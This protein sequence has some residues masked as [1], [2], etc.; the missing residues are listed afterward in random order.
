MTIVWT[1]P[2]PEAALDEAA[3][4]EDA[5]AAPANVAE[6]IRAAAE[7]LEAIDA[8]RG[9]LAPLAL[10]ERARLL[11]AARRVSNPD[12]RARRRLVKA[13]ARQRR[14]AEVAAEEAVLESTG[15]R[16]LRRKPVFTSPN[17]YP[18]AA[19][20]DRETPPAAPAGHT[21]ETR[22]CYVCKEHYR[23]VHHFYDQLCP[24]CAELNF[25]KRTELAD[26]R[27]RV[28]LLTGG[29]VKIG[30]QAG[31]KLLR[32][33]AQLL[34]TTRFPRDSA[35]RFAAEPDFADWADRLQIFGL[36]LR[37]TPSVEAFCA[38]LLHTRSRLDF[39][40]N[41]ACQTVRRP[42]GFYQHMMAAEGAALHDLP[43]HVRR[44][45]GA[46]EGLRAYSLL[47]EAPAQSR[48]ADGK[49]ALP[50]LAERLSELT[51]ITHAAALSQVALLPEDHAGEHDLFPQGVLDQDLQQVD[52]RG[53]NSWRLLL[54]EVSSVELLEVQLVNAVA[55]FVLNAR[56]KSLMI[57][58]PE[59]DKHIVNVSAM[60]GQ[61]YRNQ[62]TT[63]HPHTNMAKAALNMMTRTSAADYVADG[64]HMNS[65][66]TGWVTDED[67]A[68][69]AA[70]K[71]VE[72]RFHPPLDIVDG[73]AR[74]VDPIL[75][76]IN[77]GEHV[78]GKFL[79][80]YRPT[81]W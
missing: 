1:D 25:R 50:R 12:N 38:E 65:V 36:D 31:L 48:D 51:G 6:R 42:P 59:R 2:A 8:D 73:G 79:K 81:D 70:K 32:S 37:H 66:D 35:K 61:F 18:P 55:P 74:I 40:V 7:I 39:I 19:V 21:A 41:N 5:P 44:L 30:Y 17:V 23:E 15:I 77:R 33:G 10:E 80:D 3:R 46:Y 53:R 58:T 64:I 57:R 56:L 14:R 24:A 4:A 13:T 49:D 67:P 22:H 78:W 71:T 75:D 63:R 52:L 72:H 27:G 34:V 28:A 68:A 47:P 60:E 11:R 20:L 76:G 69:I 29:R 26:L 43:E 45:V 16:A 54:A 62:K 9:L